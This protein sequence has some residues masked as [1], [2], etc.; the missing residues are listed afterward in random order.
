MHSLSTVLTF[1]M[2][3]LY[4]LCWCSAFDADRLG[5]MPLW[6]RYCLLVGFPFSVWWSFADWLPW[7]VVVG[8]SARALVTL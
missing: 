5:R 3:A 2:A 7:M 8:A 4:L 6:N 1:S